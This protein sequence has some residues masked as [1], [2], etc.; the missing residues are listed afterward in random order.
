MTKYFIDEEFIDDGKTIDLISIGIVCE[1]GR[2]LYL[3]SCEFERKNAS[4]W[5][6]E[7]VLAHLQMCP[8]A[9]VT[10][11]I[12]GLYRADRAYHDNVQHG[13]CVDQ[14]RGRIHNCPWRTRLQIANELRTFM[15]VE[16]Y[17]APEFYGWITG[18]DY[19]ALCQLF[20]IMLYLPEGWPHYIRDL[21]YELDLQHVSDDQLPQQEGQAHNALEDARH[22]KRL[23]DIVL[24]DERGKR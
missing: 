6:R 4:Q 16:K 24:L 1:D 10:H 5:V 12:E 15:D 13:Q 14:Q 7:N 19:V 21:Q 3:Q 20:G 9:N 23:W 8:W 11:A 2:E 18:Y 22:I 17:G